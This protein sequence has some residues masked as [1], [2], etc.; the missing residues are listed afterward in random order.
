MIRVDQIYRTRLKCAFVKRHGIRLSGPLLGG[1]KNTPELVATEQ[2]QY[3]YY[4]R[5]RNA[6]EDKVGQGKRR[7]W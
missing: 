6:V 5:K 1:P 3:I 7:F 4:Q 2:Q